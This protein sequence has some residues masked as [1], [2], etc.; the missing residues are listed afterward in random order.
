MIFKLNINHEIS[1]LFKWVKILCTIILFNKQVVSTALCVHA[2]G[3]NMA[4]EAGL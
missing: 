3:L 2:F 1:Y 4:A